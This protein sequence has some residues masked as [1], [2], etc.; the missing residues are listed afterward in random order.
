MQV[1]GNLVQNQGLY[2]VSKS[3]RDLHR[4]I[5]IDFIMKTPSNKKYIN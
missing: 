3:S 4:Y 1:F 2:D 5:A